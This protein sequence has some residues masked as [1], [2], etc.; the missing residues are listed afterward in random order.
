MNHPEPAPRSPPPPRR[1]LRFLVALLVSGSALLWFV[2]GVEW[3]PLADTLGSVKLGWVAAASA[4]LVFEFVLRA[5]RWQALLSPLGVKSRVADLFAAQ[6][7]GAAANTLFPL[8]AG[9]IAKP[10]VAAERTG[11]PL[12]TVIAT[13]VME[14]V[15]D[16]FGMV[17]VLVTMVLV[18]PTPE[19]TADGELVHNLKQYGGM[20]GGLALACLGVFFALANGEARARRIFVGIVSIAPPPLRRFFLRLFD[21]FVGGLGSARDIS[22]LAR[23][24]A[25][26]VWMWFDGALAIWC[27]FQAFGMTLPFGA[28]CFTAV[29]IALTV[30]LPQ[31][32]GFLG[33]FHVAME[34]TMVLWGQPD[35]AAQGF[36]IVFWAVSF[37]PVTAIG[38]AAMWREGLSSKRLT[39]LA[40]SLRDDRKTNEDTPARSALDQPTT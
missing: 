20:L 22:A 30:A 19:D 2:S 9:E 21:G 24:G 10:V 37:L 36:A 4:I 7:V 17:T 25:L 23:A 28:A 18:L 13:T 14:R 16:L 5:I 32:P 6:V 11:T 35:S 38:V 12:V 26:S 3:A 40:S 1:G 29:A 31:A 39:A 15:F 34:K 8:R 33:V 27:L